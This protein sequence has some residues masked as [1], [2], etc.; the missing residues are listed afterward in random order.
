MTADIYLETRK[1]IPIVYDFTGIGSGWG[2]SDPA[3]SWGG[4]LFE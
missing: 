1:G 4:V 2:Y 3:D